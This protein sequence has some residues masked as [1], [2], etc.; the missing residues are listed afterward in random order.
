MKKN[1]VRS[2]FLVS[3][4]MLMFASPASAQNGEAGRVILQAEVNKG[5]IEQIVADF[6]VANPEFMWSAMER[7]LQHRLGGLGMNNAPNVSGP[8]QES[9]K[10]SAQID[11]QGL[12]ALLIE[13]PGIFVRAFENAQMFRQQEQERL[14]RE[15]LMQ[16]YDA[17]IDN[18]NGLVVGN[19]DG[20]VTL[21]EF[22]DFNCSF[23]K[24]ASA[25][26]KALK[27][28]DKNLRIKLVD[29][30]VL[31]QGSYDA[32]LAFM[33]AQNQLDTASSEEMFYRLLDAPSQVD[34]QIAIRIAVELGADENRLR[35]DMQSPEISGKLAANLE[36]ARSVGIGG[37][38][39]WVVG[40]KVIVGA[41]GVD[42]L[43]EAVANTRSCGKADC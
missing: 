25:D 30:P 28:S 22:F 34:G 9:P 29:M 36:L 33:A 2:T 20:D 41:V 10:A 8:T 38:P 18:P 21:V 11:A 5:T 27:E 43:R 24:K 16:N 26:L 31:G 39:T 40:E 1:L 4:L 42:P 14:Q 3:A 19:P 23:C 7:A 32:S 13:N 37:T 6:L 35:A 12:E 15:A 17:V